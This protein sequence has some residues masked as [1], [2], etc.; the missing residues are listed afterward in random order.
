MSFVVR[1]T[2]RN[3]HLYFP[4]SH[5]VHTDDPAGEDLPSAQSMQIEDSTPVVARSMMCFPALQSQQAPDPASLYLPA[6]QLEKERSDEVEALALI[7]HIVFD[8][9]SDQN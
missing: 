5:V 1:R 4:A 3:A 2:N 7:F 6:E 8:G 9:L